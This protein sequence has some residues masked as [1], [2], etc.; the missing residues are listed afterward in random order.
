MNKLIA[1]TLAL[2]LSCAP[3]LARNIAVPDKDPSVVLTIPDTWNIR[4]IDYGYSAVSPGQNVFFSVEYAKAN[5]IDALMENNDNWM[6]ENNIKQ[7]KPTKVEGNL[8]GIDATIFQFDTTDDNGPTLVDFVLMPAGKK[9]MMMLT[10]WG[11][12]K[13]RA[14]HKASI[15]SIMNSVKPLP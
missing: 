4:E 7:V 13:D 9:R 5:E 3:A 10:L 1:G 14:K 8:N 6:K 11:S 2:V 12:E 15:D